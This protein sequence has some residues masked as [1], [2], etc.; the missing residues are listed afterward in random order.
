MGKRNKPVKKQSSSLTKESVFP[1]GLLDCSSVPGTKGGARA[2]KL[3][4]ETL[5]P[6]Y[7]WLIRDFMTD[8]ECQKWIRFVEESKELD[9]MEQ[10]GTRYLAARRCSR[11]QRND[12]QTAS[13]L[14]DRANHICQG[15]S[16][17]GFDKDGSTEIVGCNPNLR[18][19]RYDPGDA[20]GKHIDESNIVPGMGVT[21]LTVLIY[22]SSCIGGATRFDP[23]PSTSFWCNQNA[24]K[25][26]AFEPV[27]GTMLLHLHGDDCLLHQADPVSKG[28]KY[29]LR[30]DMVYADKR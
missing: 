28:V 10:R 17:H 2:R 5:L 8:D 26:I 20:F 7:I 11:L 19:Y 12:P 27:A 3:K 25:D 9:Q 22:L 29:V 21:K 6:G 23:P 14:F 18:V 16:I 1:G 24:T 4:A 13:R 15:L 30:T